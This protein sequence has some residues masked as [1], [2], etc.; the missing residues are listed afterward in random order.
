MSLSKTCTFI[1]RMYAVE[2]LSLNLQN[3]RVVNSKINFSFIMKDV[4]KLASLVS[5][6]HLHGL[7]KIFTDNCTQL[8]TAFTCAV[9][10]QLFNEKNVHSSFEYYWSLKF[11]TLPTK[12]LCFLKNPLNLRYAWERYQYSVI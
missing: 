7:L 2:D 6:F 12:L 4:V 1:A 3:V 8:V 5:N 9:R 10:V 11:R